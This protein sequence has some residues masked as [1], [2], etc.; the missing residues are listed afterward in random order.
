MRVARNYV[1]LTNLLSQRSDPVIEVTF[2][3]LDRLVGGLPES[4]RKYPAW[5]ANSRTAQPHARYWLDAKRRASP[6]FNAGRVRF[7]TGA[8]TVGQPR[9]PRPQAG[10]SAAAMTATGETIE[11]SVRFEWLAGGRVTLDPSGKLAFPG[12][13]ARPGVYRFT[14]TDASEVL[15]GV[16]IG[17]SDNLARRMGNYRKPGPTQPTNERIHT[18]FREVV[19]NG[20]TVILG[21]AVDLIVDDEAL[22]LAGKPARLLAESAALIRARQDGLPIENL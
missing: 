8:E 12:V 11:A 22:D 15:V 3:E 19:G 10:A 18:R 6:D 14:L 4:A 20:G 17:E 13:P 16:Y 1:A 5:W 2:T 9:S 7:E 21:F